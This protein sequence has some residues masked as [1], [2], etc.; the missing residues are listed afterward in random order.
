VS[1]VALGAL[2]LRAG[3]ALRTLDISAKSCDGLTRDNVLGALKRAPA[4]AGALQELRTV[5]ESDI[6]GERSQRGGGADDS[7]DEDED[8][9][10]AHIERN[11]EFAER[12]FG[13][14]DV[15]E[16]LDACGA[17]Q[18]GAISVYAPA[19]GGAAAAL[20]RLPPGVRVLLLVRFL[21]RRTELPETLAAGAGA[22]LTALRIEGHQDDGGWDAMPDSIALA[23][24][25][26]VLPN[27]R[28]LRLFYAGLGGERAA[29]LAPLLLPGGPPLRELVIYSSD[30]TAAGSAALTDAM[31]HNTTLRRV[32]LEA[33]MLNEEATPSLAAALTRPD[34]TLTHVKLINVGLMAEAA[35][36]PLAAAME[37]NRSVRAL[38]L[39][40][41]PYLG[42]AAA[43]A[44]A[45]SLAHNS[46]LRVLRL[47]RT[48]IGDAGWTALANALASSAALRTLDMRDIGRTE[49]VGRG[50][51]ALRAGGAQALARL[52]A[53]HRG[54]RT[55]RL[56]G[57]MLGGARVAALARGLGANAGLRRLSLA[58]LDAGDDGAAALA[59]ALTRVRRTP[60]PAAT[61]RRLCFDNNNLTAAGAAALAS[62]LAGDAAPTLT[63]LTLNENQIGNAGAKAIATALASN[64]TLTHL[65]MRWT[66]I[67]AAGAAALGRALAA[68]GIRLA[69]LDV[70]FNY[71]GDA[72]AKALGGALAAN[73]S[74]T[75]LGV[76][77]CDFGNAGARALARGV[78]A[79]GTL[80]DMDASENDDVGD[81]GANALRAAM[82]AENTTLRRLLLGPEH[83]DELRDGP[84]PEALDE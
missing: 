68:P 36:A 13:G 61:L 55:L 81:A 25:L 31:A 70:A 26:A 66:S 51:G 80:R 16:L 46:T 6:D 12:A 53:T 34:A 3:A 19:G 33:C 69:H 84:D 54:L 23:P 57:G 15:P 60:A 50:R 83:E 48:A 22:A 35:F 5:R 27:L 18:R 39:C 24:A 40:R 10:D 37:R 62:A 41:N 67:T 44:L 8:G 11:H 71:F 58:S 49:D 64:T 30:V 1:G 56:D 28:S 78:A 9:Y 14:F 2:C 63:H 29:T 73:A 75:Y 74:L 77:S 7:E 17:L 20:R 38:S 82:R 32:W 42:D 43:E 65:C 45:A 4:A 52:L 21:L 76:R 72:G 47:T 59:A 79:N